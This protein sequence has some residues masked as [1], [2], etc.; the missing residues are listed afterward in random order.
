MCH[1]VECMVEGAGREG[2]GTEAVERDAGVVDDEV[3][4]IAVCLLQMGR[5]TSDAAA[6]CDV[7]SV[8][9]YLGQAAVGAE[10][11]GLLQLRVLL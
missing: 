4:A 10:R 1:V 8:V 7:E 11:L 2:W 3:D 5:E 9:F 6:V